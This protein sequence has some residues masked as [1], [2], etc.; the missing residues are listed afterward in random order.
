MMLFL[1]KS[2]THTFVLSCP[3]LLL[4]YFMDEVSIK[5]SAMKKDSHNLSANH[6]FY[7]MK[8]AVKKKK[9]T[10]NKNKNKNTQRLL[11]WV[12]EYNSS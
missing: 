5:P 12:W 2:F 10:K 9:T 11:I 1:E 8:Y 7:I 4:V 6:F 3:V